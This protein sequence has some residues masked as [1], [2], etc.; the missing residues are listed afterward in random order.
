MKSINAS[1]EKCKEEGTQVL[2]GTSPY[3]EFYTNRI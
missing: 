2:M 3:I 1:A